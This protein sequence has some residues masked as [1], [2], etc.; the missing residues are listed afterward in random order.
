MYKMPCCVHAV[1]S[2][3][4][5]IILVAWQHNYNMYRVLYIASNAMHSVTELCICIHESR[6]CPHS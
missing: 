1:S 3:V 5:I 2:Y 4:A 6:L